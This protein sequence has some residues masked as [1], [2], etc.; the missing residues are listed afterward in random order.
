MPNP[1]FSAEDLMRLRRI[2]DPQVS[3]D[4]RYVAFSVA[5]PDLEANAPRMSLWLLDLASRERDPQRVDSANGWNGRWAPDSRGLYFLS[6]RSGSSQVWHLPIPSGAATQVT[7]L[8]LDVETFKV[9]PAG[10]RLLLSLEVFPD[11]PD[12]YGTAARL[13]AAA[14]SGPHGQVHDRLFIRH[15][16]R[17]K[18]DRQS[19]L[20]SLALTDGTHVAGAPVDLSGRLDA[21][22]PSKPRGGDEEF[23][24][25]PDGTRVVFTARIKGED[26]A[27]STN[28]DV[29]E[30]SADG[31]GELRNLTADNR[32][33]DA[34]PI[35]S[36]DGRWLAWKAMDRPQNEADRFHLMLRD[37]R[38][39]RVESLAGDWDRS[40]SRFAFSPDSRRILA[41]TDHLGQRV[42]WSLELSTGEPTLVT[43]QGQVTEFCVGP[44]SVVYGLAALDAPVDLYSLDDTGAEAQRLTRFNKDLLGARSFGDFEQFSFP[45]WNGEVVYGYVMRP[46]GFDPTRKYPLALLVHGGPQMSFANGWSYRWNP[47]VYA[48]WGYA[49]VLIDYHGSTGY[50]QAFTDS[51]TGDWGGKPLEDLRLGMAAACERYTW[52]DGQRA[53]AIGASYGGFMMNWIEGN[54]RD[55]FRCL[56]NYAGV[57]DTRGLYYQTDEMWLDE[58]EFGGPQFQV[59]ERYEE[60]NPILHVAKWQ[61]PML[62]GHG[63]LDCNVPSS[64][65]VSTFTALQR[66]G[67]E[68]RLLI[69]PNEGHFILG[70]RNCLQWHDEV[71][72]WLDRWTRPSA[73]P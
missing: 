64:Q 18:D 21:D 2:S 58:Y 19:H 54:W 8:P 53:C 20:F 35:Y 48:G 61:T 12:L 23:N 37:L 70:P 50:G 65:G 68:S 10:D 25:S 41:I 16:D 27:W 71:H 38:S 30:T 52:I 56:V 63:L 7:R 62:V 13:E 55:G 17:W 51:I 73:T 1:P 34:E 22:V 60:H 69:F 33:W 29:F 67:I 24:F 72:G 26:E 40:I 36:P 59:P 3:P 66:R 47:Q 5:E 57:F 9:S 43:S 11:C 46:Y 6:S 31:R 42:L 28:F 32:A 49:V 14:K 44:E 4:G 45:G 15:W 39:G